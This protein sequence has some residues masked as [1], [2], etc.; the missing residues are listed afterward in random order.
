MKNISVLKFFLFYP[1]FFS[2]ILKCYLLSL[3]TIITLQ[4][5]VPAK[6]SY[7]KIYVP[8]KWMLNF[9]K[10]GYEGHVNIK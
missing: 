2:K 8:S 9:D 1:N 3:A 6:M 7:Q 10:Y 5:T 4:N